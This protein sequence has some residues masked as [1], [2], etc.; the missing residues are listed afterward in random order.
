LGVLLEERG[1]IAEAESWYRLSAEARGPAAMDNLGWLLE[2]RGAIVEAETW[3][4][5]AAEARGA[6][7]VTDL[8]A[9]SP[10]RPKHRRTRAD[11]VPT[12]ADREIAMDPQ[13]LFA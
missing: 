10:K 6:R 2:E 1:A 5:R 3:H 13:D 11:V 9:T 8:E 12:S 4:R 7:R